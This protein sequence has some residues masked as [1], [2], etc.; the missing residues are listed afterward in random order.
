MSTG[1]TIVVHGG[2]AAGMLV[3]VGYLFAQLA[4]MWLMSQSPVRAGAEIDVK[5]L[6]ATLEWR[7]PLTMAAMGF[8]FV[9]IGE[10][11]RSF[12]KSKAKAAV[13]PSPSEVEMQRLLKQ[14]ET[15]QTPLSADFA[16]R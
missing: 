16:T 15:S 11:L 7:L 5:P 2:I 1:K 13:E 8:V 4:G 9:A 6:V 12:W 3:V 14:H 10:G